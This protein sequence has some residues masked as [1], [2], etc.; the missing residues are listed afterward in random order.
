MTDQKLLLVQNVAAKLLYEATTPKT[1]EQI[2]PVLQGL[3][4]LPIRFEAQFKIFV[5][6]LS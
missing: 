6:V 1:L 4:C 3:F 2:Y 5:L